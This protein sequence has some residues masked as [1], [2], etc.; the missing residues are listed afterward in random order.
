MLTVM[1]NE[2][3][4]PIVVDGL[5]VGEIEKTNDKVHV[6]GLREVWFDSEEEATQAILERRSRTHELVEQHR[7][8]QT[9]LKVKI[10]KT[11]YDAIVDQGLWVGRPVEES[12]TQ[13]TVEVENM[14]LLRTSLQALINNLETQAKTATRTEG[15]AMRSRALIGAAKQQLARL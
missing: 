8:Q 12:K 15:G 14:D 11:L 2:T 4:K 10:G 6:R 9:N 5:T 13:T 7:Q 3:I 1:T